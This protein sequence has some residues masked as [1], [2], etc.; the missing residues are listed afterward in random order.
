MNKVFFL[1]MRQTARRLRKTEKELKQ[2][3]K[4]ERL[5]DYRDR[6]KV[7]FRIDEVEALAKEQTL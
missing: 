4:Q 1:S 6:S 2:M 3:V 7:L 5:Q